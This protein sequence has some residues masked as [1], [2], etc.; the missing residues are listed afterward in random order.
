MFLFTEFPPTPGS[1][2]PAGDFKDLME[3]FGGE[4][5]AGSILA[6]LVIANTTEHPRFSGHTPFPEAEAVCLAF[7]EAHIG[8]PRAGEGPAFEF[9]TAVD[10]T[11][12]LADMRMSA[13]GGR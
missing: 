2:L 8:N 4:R 11:L 5:P 7:A 10:A 13:G 9:M 6:S 3:R 1:V 12:N